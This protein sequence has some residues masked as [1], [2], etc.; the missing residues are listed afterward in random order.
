MILEIKSK[1]INLRPVEVCDIQFI[2]E[3]RLKKGKFLSDTN[4][5][6]NQ[7]KEWIE[8]Y[9]KREA[10]KAEY[11]FIIED[12]NGLAVGTARLYNIDYQIGI[13]TFGS[14]II[15]RDVAPKNCAPESMQ[16]ILDFAFDQLHLKKCIFDCRKNN[17]RANNFYAKF[18]A[19][20]VDSDDLN[21]YYEINPKI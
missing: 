4:P 6:L 13:F 21:F 20:I 7:Q 14:F 16:A 17:L 11:Y 3:L 5:D 9:K 2:V 8:D 15:D 1:N 18:G 10:K 19:K 12:K